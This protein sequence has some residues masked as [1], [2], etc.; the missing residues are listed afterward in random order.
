[1]AGRSNRAVSRSVHWDGA[2]VRGN[3]AVAKS[4]ESIVVLTLMS[5]AK[6]RSAGLSTLLSQ[7]VARIPSQRPPSS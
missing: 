1:M 5:A 7:A 3:R 6:G 2:W 4:G